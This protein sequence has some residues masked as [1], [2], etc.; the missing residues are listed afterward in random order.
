MPADPP[1]V[2]PANSLTMRDKIERI[3]RY[4]FDLEIHLKQ[5]EVAI[6]QEE[7]SRARQAQSDL[8]QWA[9]HGT[10]P[11]SA[12]TPANTT[13]A[14]AVTP[15]VP[16]SKRHAAHP[17]ALETERP[18]RRRTTRGEPT[19]PASKRPGNGNVHEGLIVQRYD[20][21]T[22]KVTCPT[23][24]REKFNSLQ[25]FLNHT[26]I[27]HALEFASHE[28]A[29]RLCGAPVGNSNAAD[30]NLGQPA[31]PAN[32]L[33][34]NWLTSSA[35]FLSPPVTT[36]PTDSPAPTAS[37]S[38]ALMSNQALND[39]QRSQISA[40]LDYIQ[41]K[42]AI[43]VFEEDVD[44]ESD[45]SMQTDGASSITP[46]TGAAAMHT[47]GAISRSA[48]KPAK[49]PRTTVGSAQSQS[50]FS[51]NHAEPGS[52]QLPVPIPSLFGRGANHHR[53][54]RFYI[55]KRILVGNVSKYLPVSKRPAEF[56]DYHYK[57][58]LYVTTPREDDRLA[59]FVDRIQVFLHPSYQPYDIVEL[60]GP[61]FQLT[62]F[63]WGEFP[64]KL[65]VYFADRRNKP[66][67]I[68]H[69]LQ[70][71]KS[72]CG[73]QVPGKEQ[74]IDLELDRNTRFATPLN[75]MQETTG[76]NR[77]LTQHSLANQPLDDLGGASASAAVVDDLPVALFPWLWVAADW[78]PLV[79]AVGEREHW[80]STYRK[81]P[82]TTA[83][84]TKI[85]WQ[86][87]LGK[88][89]AVEWRRAR[90]IHHFLTHKAWHL[91]PWRKQFTKH[92]SLHVKPL[93]PPDPACCPSAPLAADAQLSSDTAQPLGDHDHPES[94]Q[95]PVVSSGPLANVPPPEPMPAAPMRSSQRRSGMS[96]WKPAHAKKSDLIDQYFKLLLSTLSTK[97]IVLWCRRHGATPLPEDGNVGPVKT[98][99]DYIN[100]EK[101]S[102]TTMQTSL[103][104]TAGGSGE[105]GTQTVP[106]V[107]DLA[108]LTDA[109][110]G[111]ALK[112]TATQVDSCTMSEARLSSGTDIVACRICGIP[113][114][115]RFL[116]MH[117]QAGNRCD[118]QRQRL[119]NGSQ[120]S[121]AGLALDVNNDS[122]PLPIGNKSDANPTRVQYQAWIRK[123]LPAANQ[124]LSL[125]NIQQ[126]IADGQQAIANGLA[127]TPQPIPDVAA[128]LSFVNHDDPGSPSQKP[129][130]Y[131]STLL[132]LVGL[133][134]TAAILPTPWY[135]SIKE[136]S[137]SFLTRY[138]GIL[139]A[140]AIRAL[141]FDS[142]ASDH[143][144][145][146]NS[147][148]Q[149]TLIKRWVPL[150]AY[151]QM[152]N[153]IWASI[154]P[155]QLHGVLPGL[156]ND[157]R[158][159]IAR[160]VNDRLVSSRAVSTEKEQSSLQQAIS[161]AN[162]KLTVGSVLVTAMHAFIGHLIQ[163]SIDQCSAQN[164]DWPVTDQEAAK[165]HV[166]DAEGG[167]EEL[168]TM[169]RDERQDISNAGRHLPPRSLMPMH[170]YR[171][172]LAD[173]D[174][175]DFLLHD[176]MGVSQLP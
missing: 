47:K 14:S 124:P 158:L 57:W 16:L 150:V 131:S 26:R 51:G 83:A 142:A 77:S 23:C 102:T 113:T 166:S 141:T 6:I 100:E 58:M 25:G 63:G 168:P 99:L 10:I 134:S 126:A 28:E 72:H 18:K 75:P 46:A 171:A 145:T 92:A 3:I 97:D 15:A 146:S 9:A 148:E 90:C 151:S 44:L 38:S 87:P 89:R 123:L 74:I 76:A 121:L 64:I 60:T 94:V 36:T 103:T 172:C 143:P 33:N 125:S 153:W 19:A 136:C 112:L 45:T 106:M 30:A 119:A 41:R 27:T 161:V 140:K 65:K 114:P 156:A 50:T 62:R 157:M 147:S 66:I 117:L 2:S 128:L 135:S 59:T 149:S 81:L 71:D 34:P 116:A 173:R 101:A 56:R 130:P 1:P 176:G 4:Q 53:D 127:T 29:V 167:D 11:E 162:Q 108:T 73:N 165:S 37:G 24:H 35:N 111:S 118:A 138:Y 12:F 95:A 21:V 120:G 86:W 43:K 169:T 105:D 107:P 78:Y 82:Y 17:L 13:T 152:L 31:R 49:Y 154:L 69:P 122:K 139:N 175:F 133:D 110:H 174:R 164:P 52:L 68:I 7:L 98:V 54:S 109:L 137:P 5:R 84:N 155:L 70:L 163:R 20:G 22:V 132:L 129:R 159:A 55:T 91:A 104:T 42:P 85:F 170:V 96:W 48:I 40:A 160:R 61:K 32:V 115:A 144:L 79:L 67:D 80:E 8:E 93:P 88:R 39:L